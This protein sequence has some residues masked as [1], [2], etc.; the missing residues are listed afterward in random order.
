MICAQ[1][2]WI[3]NCP[4][5]CHLLN[6][7]SKDLVVGFA[8]VMSIVSA[9]TSYFSHSNYGKYHL[10]EELKKETDKRGIQAA[11]ATR[12]STFSINAKSVSRCW[13]AMQ[14]CYEAGKLN[15]TGKGSKTVEKCLKDGEDM[16]TFKTNLHHVT[17]ILSPIERGLRTLEGQNTTVSDVLSIF[18]GIAIAFGRVFQDPKS[19]IY[20][21]RQESY[22]A[23]NRRFDKLIEGSTQ[24][25]FWIGFLLDP[26]YYRDGALRLNL[27]PRE[28]FSRDS[29]SPFLLQL[30]I[31][32]RLMLSHE[33]QRMQSGGVAEADRLVQE[34]KAYLYQDAPFD[35]PCS[36]P[37]HRLTWWKSRLE[38]N[39]SSILAIL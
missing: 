16:Y 4:D 33:Q 23:F 26:I 24:D 34:L 21:Y 28:S 10:R 36:A 25:M 5:P 14:R 9:I 22:D 27:P 31:S 1:W 19:S 3:L 29:V 11:G 30:L 35:Q 13:A 17:T 15:F 7:L 38:D 6:L 18:I 8:D 32:A 2:P 39:R 37:E 12:F 20:Q